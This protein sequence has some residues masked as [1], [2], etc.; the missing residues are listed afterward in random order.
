MAQEC[1]LLT[2]CGFF[3]NYKGNTEVIKVGWIQ[4][5]CNSLEKSEKGER[6]KH[7]KR[8]GTPP[9]D[10]MTPSGKLLSADRMPPRQ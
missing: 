9:A 3:A 6:K 1:E 8:T 7:R 4:I 5:Y 10:N 2:K